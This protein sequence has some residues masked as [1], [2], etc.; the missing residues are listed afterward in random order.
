MKKSKQQAES[1]VV[2]LVEERFD[3]L[4]RLLLEGSINQ[5]VLLQLKNKAVE[6][7]ND[8]ERQACD[9]LLL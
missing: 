5:E 1:D 8:I 2:Q 6:E 4:N 3:E 7:L 9:L